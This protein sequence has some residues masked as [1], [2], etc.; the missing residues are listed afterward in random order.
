[1]DLKIYKPGQGV[2]AR[3]S[4]Y[5][6]FAA[7]LL[8]GARSLHSFLLGLPGPDATDPFLTHDF[9]GGPLPLVGWQLT[10]SF[11]VVVVL[12]LAA[13]GGGHLLLNLPKSADLLIDTEIELRKVTWA[14]LRDA[15]S[16][17]VVV[18]GTVVAFGLLLAGAD[19][20]FNLVLMQGLL[21]VR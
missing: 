14:S 21:G 10:G 19:F 5:S 2:A 15:I 7:L 9:L 1:M 16:S 20:F 6:I 3:W 12:F 11:L 13:L 18:I 8:Y 17:S 4:A